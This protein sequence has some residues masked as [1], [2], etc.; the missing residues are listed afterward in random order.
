MKYTLG[1]DI[2]LLDHSSLIWD[3]NL[4]CPVQTGGSYYFDFCLVLSA[5]SENDRSVVHGYKRKFSEAIAAATTRHEA[6]AVQPIPDS[7]QFVAFTPRLK[8]SAKSGDLASAIVADVANLS[9]SFPWCTNFRFTH[10]AYLDRPSSSGEIIG[11]VISEICRL[12][13]VG[14][15]RRWI[16][17]VGANAQKIF[18]E[19]LLAAGASVIEDGSDPEPVPDLN[20]AIKTDS[21][22]DIRHILGRRINLETHCGAGMTYLMRAAAGDKEAVAKLLI[23]KGASLETEDEIGRTALSIAAGGGA[24]RVV[25]LLLKHGA[26]FETKSV[27]GESPLMF[28]ANSGRADCVQRLLDAGANRSLVNVNGKSAA[29]FAAGGSHSLVVDMLKNS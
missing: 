7:R 13:K 12:S 21:M 28:A 23:E 26:N 1:S 11:G 18:H 9:L 3:P 29:D 10:F 20:L 2:I 25:E 16:F 4:A 14:P 24:L 6:V 19:V 27:R 8:P 22:R 5:R 17:N 15:T